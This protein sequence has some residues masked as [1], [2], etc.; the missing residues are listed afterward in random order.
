MDMDR[1]D[2]HLSTL[3][4]AICTEDGRSNA[5]RVSVARSEWTRRRTG[6]CGELGRHPVRGPT[7]VSHPRLVDRREREAVGLLLEP[8]RA[9]LYGR[10]LWFSGESEMLSFRC[11]LTR[12]APRPR[13]L[14]IR[15]PDPTSQDSSAGHVKDVR[16]FALPD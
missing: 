9:C 11:E 3:V 13:L 8:L 4:L 12:L 6:E 14:L 15:L 10:W 16:R 5:S 2:G 1:V 7:T